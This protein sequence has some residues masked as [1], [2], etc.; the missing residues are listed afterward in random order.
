MSDPIGLIE[1]RLGVCYR[2]CLRNPRAAVFQVAGETGF[3]GFGDSRLTAL[4][5]I[6]FPASVLF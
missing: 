3:T 4:G 6:R 1:R 5:D 2:D